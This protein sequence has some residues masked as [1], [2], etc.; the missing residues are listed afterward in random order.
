MERNMGKAVNKVRTPNLRFE[1]KFVY[2]NALPEDIINTE[3]FTN[4]FC[5]REIFHRRTVNNC[6]FDDQAMSFYHQNVAGDDKRDKYRLRWYGDD[7]TKIKKPVLEI[8]KKHGAVGD[9]LSFA[10]NHLEN[11]LSTSSNLLNKTKSAIEQIQEAE[12][13]NNMHALKPSLYNS[14]ERRYFLS[15][16]ERFRITI[17]YNMK[18]YNPDSSPYSKGEITL[19]DVVLELKYDVSNDKVARKLSQ[20]LSARLS[21]HSKYVRGVDRIHFQQHN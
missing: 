9:K 14:Y 2:A 17:D 13:A 8:K 12:L 1:R 7:F 21:K 6:Y 3:V 11:E 15:H 5:F 19:S 10:L 18:F 16:C 4:S 20:A